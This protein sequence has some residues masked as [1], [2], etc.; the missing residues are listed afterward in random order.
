[1]PL[2][3]KVALLESAFEKDLG[4]DRMIPYVQLH[5]FEALLFSKPSD[6]SVVFPGEKTKIKK[7]EQAREAFDSPEHIDD[8]PNT[9]PSKQ[10]LGVFPG[11]AK[12]SDG[13]IVAKTI[14]LAKMRSECKHFDEWI[15]KLYKNKTT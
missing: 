8:G 10:I 12:T 7:L 15:Q 3:E 2:D 11:Y 4:D 6:F 9:A 14:G 5:E 13:I 1:M